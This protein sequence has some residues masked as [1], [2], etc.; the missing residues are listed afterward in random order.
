MKILVSLLLAALLSACAM[1]YRMEGD[2]LVNDK[3]AVH[4]SAAWNH[5]SDPWD[6]DPYETWTRDGMPLDHL[7]LWGGVKPG[8]PLMT[9]PMVF[10]RNEDQKAPRV[11]TFRTGLAPEQLVSLFEE[12]YASAGTVTVTKVETTVF[13]GSPGVRFEFTLLRRRDDLT[14]R[15]VVWVAVRPDPVHGEELYAAAF[16]APRLGFYDKLLPL[17]EAVVKSARVKG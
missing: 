14:L 4:V 3:L 17:A 10:L 1:A 16:V 13:A 12:L 11:P 2:Q 15:G 9:R 5:V 8:Q 6:G 7:R